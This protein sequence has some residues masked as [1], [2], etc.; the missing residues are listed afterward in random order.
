MLCTASGVPPDGAHGGMPYMQLGEHLFVCN[1]WK[2]I[3]HIHTSICL[4]IF[5]SLKIWRGPIIVLFP[6]VVALVVDTLPLANGTFQQYFDTPLCWWC[7]CPVS[8][9]GGE[10]GGILLIGSRV[11]FGISGMRCR[12]WHSTSCGLCSALPRNCRRSSTLRKPPNGSKYRTLHFFIERAKNKQ[13]HI[14]H[15]YFCHIFGQS[16]FAHVPCVFIPKHQ[17]M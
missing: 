7:L 15:P 16:A 4:S 14:G 3:I 1:L 10:R 9:K 2:C 6:P 12:V 11:Q 13:A 8:D 17:L 5:E